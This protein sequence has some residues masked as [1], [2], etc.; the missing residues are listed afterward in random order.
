MKKMGKHLNLSDWKYEIKSS[1]LV[2]NIRKKVGK[3]QDASYYL[4]LDDKKMAYLC[5]ATKLNE[6]EVTRL[7]KSF[8]VI[9]QMNMY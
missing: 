5:Q 8:M 9:Y 1:S 7:H 3:N 6:N 2:Q 4:T